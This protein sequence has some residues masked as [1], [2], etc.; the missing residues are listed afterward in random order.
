MSDPGTGRGGVSVA[1]MSDLGTGRGGVSVAR[2]SDLVTV[3]L[4]LIAGF[5]TGV[6]SGMFGVGG[7]VISTPAI[8]LLGA[9]P[10]QAVGS[11]L[12]SIIPGAA[13]G[14]IRYE[15]EGMIDHRVA[16]RTG[17]AGMAFAALGAVASKSMP[18]KGHVQM[19]LTAVLLGWFAYRTAPG[20]GPGDPPR[21]PRAEP[22][23]VAADPD[24]RDGGRPLRLPRR[25][26]RDP[27]GP[28]VHQL[29]R[30]APQ[31]GDR[32]LARLRRPRVHPGDDHAPAARRHRLA[33]RAALD[34]HG[35]PRRPGG[36]APRHPRVRTRAAHHGRER[37]RDDRGRLR[38]R[39]SS[40]R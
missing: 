19:V 40:S 16:W 30:P 8:L 31:A 12:P 26:R 36:R 11:T 23:P 22:Q 6:L 5:F 2:M 14:S 38:R 39:S 4:V 27:D 10:L 1:R 20:L 29:G 17:I 7:A 3:V 13:S 37:A 15:R 18:G 25:R 24:R 32:D 28:G 34:D 33:V 21:R 35:G 9:T